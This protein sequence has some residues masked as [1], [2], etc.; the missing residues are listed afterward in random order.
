A[1]ER[2]H[3]L[4]PEPLAERL[5][6]DELFELGN[7]LQVTPESELGFDAQL[8][9]EEPDLSQ[10]LN[11]RGGER[12]PGDIRERLAAPERKGFVPEICG[13][14]R[15]A[16]VQGAAGGPTQPVQGVGIGLLRP[17]V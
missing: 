12:L 3:Q 16:S 7:E 14:A 2:E 13:Y 4:R 5:R 15:L 17:E 9:R 6:C 10:P 8:E 11:C 1:V